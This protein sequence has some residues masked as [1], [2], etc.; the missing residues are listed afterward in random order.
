MFQWFRELSALAEGPGLVPAPIWWFLTTFCNSG[1]QEVL[2]HLLTSMW[3]IHI[4]AGKTFM[5]IKK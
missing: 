5:H 2:L 1:N 4:L 3:Y